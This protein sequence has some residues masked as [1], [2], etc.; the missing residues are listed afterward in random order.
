MATVFDVSNPSQPLVVATEML[1][2]EENTEVLSNA[3]WDFKSVQYH[4]GILAI[5]LSTYEMF[6]HGVDNWTYDS[7]DE[8]EGFVVLDVSDAANQGIKELFRV[9]HQLDYDCFTCGY[10]GSSRSY[11]FDENNSIMTMSGSMVISSDITSGDEVW[12]LNVTT[13]TI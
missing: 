5:P 11:F 7:T 13:P 4:N 2:E 12:S 9:D 8:F 3:L 6:Q 1:A 10:L